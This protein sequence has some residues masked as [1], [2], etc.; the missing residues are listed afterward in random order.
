MASELKVSHGSMQNLVKNDLHLKSFKRR[1]AHFLSEKIVKKR[2]ARSKG[3]LTRLATLPLQNIIFSDEKLFTIEEA[4][5]NQN[6]RI[7]AHTTSRITENHLFITK[8]EWPPSSPDL[9]P[10]DFSIWSILEKNACA[11]SHSSVEALKKSLHREWE[12]IPQDNL[13]ATVETFTQ[14]LKRVVEKK[15]GYIE[16]LLSNV[17]I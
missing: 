14:R 15:G 4:T 7:L 1:T 11:K 6:D 9:I 12:K 5:N 13:R 2:L 3:M 16:S 17:L 10:M 8:E